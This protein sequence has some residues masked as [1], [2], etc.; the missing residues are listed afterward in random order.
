[1]SASGRT[2][3]APV[4]VVDLAKHFGSVAAVDGVSMQIG[5]SEFVALLGPSGSGKTTIL[6]IIAGF[7]QPDS[8]DVL[9]D[10]APVTGIPANRR[11][12]GMVFQRYALF[13]HM[14]VAENIAFPLRMRGAPRAECARRVKELL[15]TVK[16][17]GYNNRR[18]SQLSGGQQQRVAFARA[19]AHR[20]QALLMDEPLA[21]LDKKLREQMQLEVKHLQRQLGIT[22]VF[23]THDQTEALTMA[24]RVA[25]LNEGKLEQVGTPEELYERPKS[26]FVADF[27]GETNFVQGRFA[28][29]ADGLGVLDAAGRVF[30]GE[31]VGES[32]ARDAPAC[33][34]VRPEKIRIA[35]APPAGA[36]G[37]S[38]R[39]QD[40]VYAG[41]TVA[42]LVHVAPA[43]SFMVRQP[44]PGLQGH[45]WRTGDPVSL[46]WAPSDARIY[47]ESSG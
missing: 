12:L 33:L 22:V 24:D 30:S 41:S 47:P 19:V 28:G 6:N 1:M 23:V 13:P 20:P 2:G 8:G 9:I 46:E 25:V 36:T 37:L 21:A 14:S 35:A 32:P 43:Q 29:M 3:G 4:E 16:L 18:P 5:A 44:A 45:R 38:G 31:L 42:Y 40:A 7:E 34:A 10:G 26:R 39:V 27:I 15:E 11:N 17:T